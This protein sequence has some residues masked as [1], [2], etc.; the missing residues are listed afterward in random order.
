MLVEMPHRNDPSE[1][2]PIADA[3]TRRVPYLSAI[4][5]LMGINTARLSV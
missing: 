2:M 4:Q 3:N 1:K 5:P